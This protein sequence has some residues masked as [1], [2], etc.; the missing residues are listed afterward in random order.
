MLS[1]ST[2]LAALDSVLV[3]V[4][5]MVFMLEHNTSIEAWLALVGLEPWR[6]QILWRLV[7]YLVQKHRTELESLLR[8]SDS[9]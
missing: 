2:R 4:A 8:K 3:M 6:C 1:S 7:R 9:Q 5:Q